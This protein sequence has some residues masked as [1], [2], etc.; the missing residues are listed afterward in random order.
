[1]KWAKNNIKNQ[2]WKIYNSNNKAG[3]HLEYLI[4]FTI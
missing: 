4:K 2:S 1:L 3:T